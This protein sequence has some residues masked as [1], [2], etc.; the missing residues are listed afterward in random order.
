MENWEWKIFTSLTLNDVKNEG[1]TFT[2]LQN[3]AK[4]NSYNF[5][6]GL[7]KAVH[8][9]KI[10]KKVGKKY[11]ANSVIKNKTLLTLKDSWMQARYFGKRIDDMKESKKPF[12]DGLL[13]IL[14]CMRMLVII[15]IE[16][17]STK[18]ANP[19]EADEFD[20]YNYFLKTTIKYVFDIL[21]KINPKRIEKLK[22]G[23]KIAMLDRD[24]IIRLEAIAKKDR[25]KLD[26]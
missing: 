26:N 2:E 4:I 16:E 5:K 9:S 19:K 15:N 7:R 22:L 21:R 10:I 8:T 13:I 1:L 14:E 12:E 17:L 6:V 20:N 11:H 23:L 24:L 18:K 25:V 3:V